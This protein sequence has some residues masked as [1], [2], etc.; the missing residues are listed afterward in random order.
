MSDDKTTTTIET[1]ERDEP[2]FE[3]T[4]FL[5]PNIDYFQNGEDFYVYHNTYGYILKMS[6][7]LVDFLEFFHHETRNAVDVDA[8]FS[9]IFDAETLNG[10]L[11]IFRTL[12]CL[13]PDADF[14]MNKTLEMYPTQARWITV[15]QTD[16]KAI[17][18]YVFDGQSRNQ[19]KRIRLDAWESELWSQLK[20]DK[21]V[22]EIAEILAESGQDSAAMLGTRI[23][24]SLALWTHSDI[25]AIK[26][27]AEPHKNYAGKRF[28]VPPYLISTMPYERVTDLVRTILDEEGNV[29]EKHEEAPRVKPE[30]E[31]IAIDDAV[32]E[33][34]RH[35]A[36]LCALLSEPHEVLGMRS[37]GAAFLDVI[38]KY[39]RIADTFTVLEIGPQSADTAKAFLAALNDKKPGSS[40]QYTI[41][42]PNADAGERLKLETQG[43]AQLSVVTGDIDKIASIL[44]GQRFDF[45]LSGEYLANLSSV[46]VRKLTPGGDNEDEFD[47]DIDPED[48]E[49]ADGTRELESIRSS[50]DDKITFIGESDAIH[51]IFK[52]KLKFADSPEDFYL[53]NGSL[54]LLGQIDKL[55]HS[56]TQIYLVEFGEDVKYPVQTF[57]DGSIAYSQHFGVLKQ[58]AQHL[59]YQAQTSYWFEELGI[60]R[61]LKMFATTRSQFKALRQLLADHDVALERSP[62]TREAF[63]ALL[64]K[65]GLTDVVEINYEDAEERIS[66]LVTHAYKLLRLHKELEF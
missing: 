62:Y 21:T 42:A 9:G 6:E 50:D 13:L 63:E 1:A 16:P 60:R 18:L 43:H 23:A 33:E 35:S 48:E 34:D 11:S 49:A 65:A 27:S 61:D 29:I 7:D 4:L 12:A 54:R 28:G 30:A 51:L 56:G 58:A 26:L 44:E 53:N 15:N 32:L 47:E 17:V 2:L 66:G 5:S 39:A 57:E 41:F 52:Y 64:K 38:A 14:E 31:I 55:S 3:G 25:Q 46:L 20:G 37:Y 40:C 22:G 45:I 10:F 24:A 36:R 19:V 59:G 8:Q